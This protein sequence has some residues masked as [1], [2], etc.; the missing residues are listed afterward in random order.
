MAALPATICERIRACF[1]R[2]PGQSRGA[3]LFWLWHVVAVVGLLVFLGDWKVPAVFESD[4]TTPRPNKFNDVVHVGLYRGALIHLFISGV[5]L[6]TVRWWGNGQATTVETKL[7]NPALRPRCFWL[8]LGVILVAAFA[9]RWPRMGHSYWG[10]EGWALRHYVYGEFLPVKG[11]DYQGELKFSP[12]PWQRTL[13][14][15]R[16]GGNHFLFSI[17]QK[18]TLDVW[19]GLNGLPEWKFDEAVSR[20]PLLGA[21]LVSIVLFALFLSWLGR[22]T[23]GLIGA[24]WFAF[25]PWHIRYSTEARGYIL[26]LAFF[27]L[28]VWVLWIAMRDGR[29]RWWMLVGVT[30]FLAIYSWKVAALPLLYVDVLA[31]CWL[32]KN[33]R[34]P[35]RQRVGACLRLIV[36]CSSM[37]AVFLFLYMPP[38]LQSPR[39]LIRLQNTGKPMNADWLKNSLSCM[40][41][42]TPWVRAAVDNP[43]EVPMSEQVTGGVIGA[44]GLASALAFLLLGVVRMWRESPTQTVMYLSIILAGAGGAALFKWKVRIEWITW[45]F[46]FLIVP[47]GIFHAMGLGWL[48][49]R[50]RA[51]WAR[52]GAAAFS[53]PLAVL[54]MAGSAYAIQVPQIRLMDWQPYES[55]REAFELT[56]GKHEPFGFAGPTNIKTCYLWRHIQLYDPRGDHNV[57]TQSRVRELMAEAERSG[58][59]FYYIV[60]LR[61]LFREMQREVMDML[62]DPALFEHITT[63]WAEEEIHTMEVYRYKKPLP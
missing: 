32:M 27:I 23:A 56:R 51:V 26:M 13:W 19:R 1:E 58:G 6:L 11:E 38:L 45:Y 40:V 62:S 44:V 42:G 35:L 25:H 37:S 28:A 34:V 47:L 4:A 46:F 39:A 5:I 53:V 54:C 31:L 33:R 41:T 30:Q 8:V 61:G 36:A 7:R 60:G 17:L 18:A 22:P 12:I 2:V 57:R 20:L 10:D 9:L 14:D 3:K 63:L 55:C 24:L 29:W 16:T 43:T 59:E 52:G 48:A 15:D 21:G 49:N 50:A